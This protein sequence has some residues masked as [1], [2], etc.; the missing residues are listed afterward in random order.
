MEAVTGRAVDHLM[1]ERMLNLLGLTATTNSATAHLPEPSLHAFASDMNNDD[2]LALRC[3]IPNCGSPIKFAG[4]E[5]E[6]GSLTLQF[7]ASGEEI[8]QLLALRGRELR[9]VL[10]ES[11]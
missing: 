2:P 3:V 4:G 1:K 11:E 7:C 9:V 10:V 6:A 5:D 8:E